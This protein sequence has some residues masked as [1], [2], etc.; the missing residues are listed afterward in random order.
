M[1]IGPSDL[2]IHPVLPQEGIRRVER[3]SD[4][5]QHPERRQPH[6]EH[7]DEGDHETPHDSVD[8]STT[9]RLAHPEHAE[10]ESASPLAGGD[11][12]DL[13][14]QLDIEA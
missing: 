14:R 10:A 9:Y 3:G 1:D 7:P 13:V 6:E 8:V 11:N 2:T 12:A 5:Q 4:A